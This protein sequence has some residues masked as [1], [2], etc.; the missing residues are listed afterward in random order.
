M[1]FPDKEAHQIFLEPEGLRRP[2]DLRERLLD[3]PAA[4]RS[5]SSSSTRCPGSRTRSMLRPGY[6]VEYDFIQPTELRRT[7]E[8][9]RVDGLFLA[10][11]INGTSGYE[12]AAAQGLMAGIN[13][14]LHVRGRAPLTLRR[15]EAY[16]GILVDDLTTQGLSRAVSDVH[17]AGGA[18]SA[19][20]DRQRGPAADAAGARDRARRRRALAR[21]LGAAR[22]PC[23][24][25]RHV[26]ESTAGR[27]MPAVASS[28]RVAVAEAPRSEAWPDLTEARRPTWICTTTW[29]VSTR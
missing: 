4:R 7:L 17:V 9:Q 29:R 8:T 12:E 3:E 6:A 16:I 10:G 5:R 18:P 24:R 2:G 1:R 21:V 11:Q 23:E 19:A 13:A 14:G 22:A 25:N 27:R 15:D 28:S 20:A 26:V